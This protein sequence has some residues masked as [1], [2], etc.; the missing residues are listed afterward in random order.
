MVSCWSRKT[1]NPSIWI[2]ALKRSG[3]RIWIVQPAAWSNNTNNRTKYARYSAI[4]AFGLV[5]ID[6]IGGAD[7][8]QHFL[9]LDADILLGTG[10]LLA[11][12]ANHGGKDAD[13]IP[14][15]SH[16]PAAATQYASATP[17]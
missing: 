6:Q 14:S 13:T 2:T 12:N 15:R 1:I 10:N 3:S 16:T 7:P 17:R 11:A 5:D 9:I 4:F 8:N